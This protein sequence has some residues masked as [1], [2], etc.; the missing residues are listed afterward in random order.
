M[1]EFPVL[2][3]Q[4]GPGEYA[5]TF[6][7][8]P[9]VRTIQPG[10]VLELFTED[11]FGGRVR[12]VS[13]LVTK[14]CQFPYVNPQTGP[15]YMDGAQPGDTT[16]SPDRDGARRGPDRGPGQLLFMPGCAPL[17]RLPA[18]N[19]HSGRKRKRS[20]DAGAADHS[21]GSARLAEEEDRSH[22]VS[23]TSGCRAPCRIRAHGRGH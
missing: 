4:P 21:G 19:H 9:P 1:S 10:T 3:Y 7:G 15:F 22:S 11:A 12:G 14:V 5:W 18:H 23:R 13:D 2:S 16:S 8:V 6:A 17:F 20:S